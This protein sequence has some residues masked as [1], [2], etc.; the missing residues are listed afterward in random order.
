MIVQVRKIINQ[1]YI[2]SRNV[3]IKKLRDYEKQNCY[4]V[5]SKNRHLTIVSIINWIIKMK[6]LI[7]L[8]LII[9]V[10]LQKS[11]VFFVNFF[12]QWK[13]FA[14]FIYSINFNMYIV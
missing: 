7:V 2:L 1:F 11:F 3:K 12:Q 10:E 14:I 13:F 9:F 4:V 8:N 5:N 6:Q